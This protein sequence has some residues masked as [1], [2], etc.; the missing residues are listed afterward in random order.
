MLTEIVTARL[1]ISDGSGT[2]GGAPTVIGAE[3][4]AESVAPVDGCGATAGLAG[5]SVWQAAAPARAAMAK[6]ART[7]VHLAGFIPVV[8]SVGLTLA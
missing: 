7:A 1:T 4:G 6:A 3:G 2:A 5:G 8:L